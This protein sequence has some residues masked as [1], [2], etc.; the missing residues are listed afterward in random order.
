MWMMMVDLGRK[1]GPVIVDLGRIGRRGSLGVPRVYKFFYE[2]WVK[3][4]KEKEQYEER[5]KA[6]EE[7][8]MAMEA[9]EEVV[10]EEEDLERNCYMSDPF[11][12]GV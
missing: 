11:S 6:M 12:G 3:K 8:P 7:A 4:E 2:E 5:R 10:E 1:L 9:E